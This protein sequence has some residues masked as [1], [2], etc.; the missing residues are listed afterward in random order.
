MCKTTIYSTNVSVFLAEIKDSRLL[1]RIRGRA[2]IVVSVPLSATME[3]TMAR[4]QQKDCRVRSISSRLWSE[5]ATL[6][7]ATWAEKLSS[8]WRGPVQ[9]ETVVWAAAMDQVAVYTLRT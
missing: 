5:G 3:F 2:A 1:S 9:V 7:A 8:G 4:L 6:T